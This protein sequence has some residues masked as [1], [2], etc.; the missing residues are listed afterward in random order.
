M[1]RSLLLQLDER[2][3][4]VKVQQI[5]IGIAIAEQ[6]EC[7]ALAVDRVPAN[8]G[9]VFPVDNSEQHRPLSKVEIALLVVGKLLQNTI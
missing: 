9:V 8:S 3:S 7:G 4:G 1:S 2:P 6:N 5:G